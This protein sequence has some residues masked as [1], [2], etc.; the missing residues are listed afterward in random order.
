MNGRPSFAGWLR[1]PE[2]EALL[3]GNHLLRLPAH[4][5]A[6]F[7]SGGPAAGLA[8]RSGTSAM[9][10]FLRALGELALGVSP[11]IG[12]GRPIHLRAQP[13]LSAHHRSQAPAARDSSSTPPGSGACS[14]GSGRPIPPTGCALRAAPRERPVEDTAAEI[15]SF[16]A[17]PAIPHPPA[18]PDRRDP[19][20]V[21]RVDPSDL[22]ELH[23]LML[24]EAFK[25]AKKVQLRVKQEVGL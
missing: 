7:R 9:Q 4:S 8:A 11:P 19:D 14:T 17:D 5:T 25:Q 24:K 21:N 15:E 2:P 18:A 6:V 12:L 23:R 16:H 20:A 22:N 3:H 10:R 1:V 13:G